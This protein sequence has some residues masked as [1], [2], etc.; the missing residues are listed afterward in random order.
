MKLPA[1][2]SKKGKPESYELQVEHE[3]QLQK[4][5]SSLQNLFEEILSKE[6][7]PQGLQSIIKV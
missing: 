3:E 5:M 2:G 1:D 7:S 6:Y 4:T